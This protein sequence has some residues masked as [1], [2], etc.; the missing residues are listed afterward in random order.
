MIEPITLTGTLGI[1]ILLL[2]KAGQH[3]W[4]LKKLSV[5][6]NCIVSKEL[7]ELPNVINNISKELEKP[8]S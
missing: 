8:K 3:L 6:S 2:I 7:E 4:R 5:N 1:C